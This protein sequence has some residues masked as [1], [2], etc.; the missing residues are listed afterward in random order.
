MS[1]RPPSSRPSPHGEGESFVVSLKIRAIKKAASVSEGR[2]AFSNLILRMRCRG[3]RC[4]SRLRGVMRFGGINVAGNHPF[5][6][7]GGIVL[8]GVVDNGVQ[9]PQRLARVGGRAAQAGRRVGAIARAGGLVVGGAVEIRDGG[10]QGGEKI[11]GQI[12]GKKLGLQRR[13]VL[14]KLIGGG[15]QCAMSAA[16]RHPK[17]GVKAGRSHVGQ[18]VRAFADGFQLVVQVGMDLRLGFGGLSAVARSG[19]LAGGLGLGLGNGG[20]NFGEQLSA[21]A[22]RGN[23]RRVFY[24]E[25]FDA[26]KSV[27]FVSLNVCHNES[28]SVVGFS[29]NVKIF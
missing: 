20:G 12:H 28:L 9:I 18:R 19:H 27:G 24:A 25:V 15:E 1:E 16:A 10:L 7:H 29:G 17:F 13:G 14:Q 22:G 8:V 5:G 3:R 21:H 4:R 26:L 11:S 23:I 6:A 2:L